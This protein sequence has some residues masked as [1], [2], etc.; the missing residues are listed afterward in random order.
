MK[1]LQK[2]Q[3]LE[4]ASKSE[5]I[6]TDLQLYSRNKHNFIKKTKNFSN[7]SGDSRVSWGSRQK[8]TGGPLHCSTPFC[9]KCSDSTNSSPITGKTLILAEVVFISITM[10]R[11]FSLVAL[12]TS[13]LL[14]YQLW[15]NLS[16]PPQAFVCLALGGKWQLCVTVANFRLHFNKEGSFRRIEHDLL[17][18]RI[19]LMSYLPI[20]L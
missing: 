1:P 7:F 18:W 12:L 8:L 9:Y 13:L 16:A 17:R 11:S 6:I 3:E 5:L 14:V 19:Q 20:R 10:L 2:C 4:G 15:D